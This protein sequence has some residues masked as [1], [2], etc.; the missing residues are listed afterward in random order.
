MSFTVDSILLLRNSCV[1]SLITYS[2]SQLLRY[3][4]LI[5]RLFTCN[6][7]K[8][9]G[10][11]LLWIRGKCSVRVVIC[12][13]LFLEF[14]LFFSF[15]EAGRVTRGWSV[16]FSCK[17]VLRVSLVFVV[18]TEEVITVVLFRPNMCMMADWKTFDGNKLVK[19]VYL[20]G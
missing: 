7:H 4:L 20:C 13:L 2:G 10:Q 15:S 8:R 3:C 1:D 18:C 5:V 11:D 6:E 12:I 9:E 16:C 17:T 19:P 14:L